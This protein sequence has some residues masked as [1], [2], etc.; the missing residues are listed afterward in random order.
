MLCQEQGGGHTGTELI[1]PNE[2]GSQQL[3]SSHAPTT[4]TLRHAN[5]PSLFPTPLYPLEKPGTLAGLGPHTGAG[6]DNGIA[7]SKNR[8]RFPHD[9]TLL[10]SHELHPHP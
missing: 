9:S 5:P 6:G 2:V 7:H 3:W 4:R 10:R 1:G 8:L